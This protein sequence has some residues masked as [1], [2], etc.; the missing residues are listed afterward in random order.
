MKQAAAANFVFI[1]PMKAL[2]VRDLP[3]GDWLYEMKFD[4]YRALAFKAGKEVRL[5]S[6]NRTN[7]DNDYPL[8]IDAL[9]LLSAKQAIIDGEIAALDD[10]GKSSFQLLQSYGKARQTPLVYYAFDLLF[11]EGADLRARPLVERRKL[12]AGVLKKAPPNI[13]FSEELRGTKEELLKVAQQFEL[14]GLMAKRPDSLYESGRRSGAWVKV[15]L[16]Q[17]QEFVIGGYTPPGGNRKYFGALL[18]GYNGPKGLLFAG[19]VGTGFSERA[20]ETLYGGLQRITRDTCPFINLPERRRGRWGQGI[21]PAV[22]KRCR[23]V[24]PVLVAQIKFTEWTLDDQ[25][26]Q[27]V[28]LGLRTDKQAKDV[29]RE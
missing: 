18:V 21:T 3:A 10:E 5:I 9:K 2:V 8:L 29:V 12:L 19:S 15:K 25:L 11:L 23:W 24:E 27:P 17:Q 28:F 22:M 1:E 13:R 20:L 7:F 26:R 14:E 6:R 16:T 4:G